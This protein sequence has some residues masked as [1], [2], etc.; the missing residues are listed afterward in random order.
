[1][2]WS[3]AKTLFGERYSSVSKQEEIYQRL[4]SLRLEEFL[5]SG[6]YE[7]SGLDQIVRRINKLVPMAKPK[8]QDDEAKVRFLR[9][10]VMGS[11]FGLRA[12][13]RLPPEPSF[14][15]LLNALTTSLRELDLHIA[16]TNAR[17]GER[18]EQPSGGYRKSFWKFHKVSPAG[19][20][21]LFAGQ[22]RYGRDLQE[23]RHTNYRVREVEGHSEVPR[24]L[25]ML[26]LWQK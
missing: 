19:A 17:P 3:V 2:S 26:Q 15:R 18:T 13:S 22:S 1:M 9:T 21:T 24:P 7:Y 11:K 8:A 23:V 6:A 20:E 10:A 16:R 12:I 25:R 5:A 14:S 4:H